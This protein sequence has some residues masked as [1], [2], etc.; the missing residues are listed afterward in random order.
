MARA[1]ATLQTMDPSARRAPNRKAKAAGGTRPTP[2]RRAYERRYRQTIRRFDLWTVLKISICFYLT[3]L[4]VFLLSA[5]VMWSVASATG[6][7]G[8]L[9]S[10]IG[11]TIGSDD[12]QLLSWN[13]LRA[14][15]LIGLVFVCL[16]VV[17]S[18]LA[19]AFYNLFS[20]LVGGIEVTVI[21]EED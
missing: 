6:I 10:S 9:E 15:T 13:L 4:I 3:A 20:D 14:T 2:V 17:M 11:D 18:V 7:I 12:F 8:N 1:K 21:E 16:A 19:A 5:I